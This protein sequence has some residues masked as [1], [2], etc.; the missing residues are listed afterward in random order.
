[1]ILF[2]VWWLLSLRGL[3]KQSLTNKERLPRLRLLAMTIFIFFAAISIFFAYSKGLALYNFSRILV[4]AIFALAT[5]GLI[6]EGIVKIDKILMALAASGI[7]QAIVGFGQFVRQ[8]SLGLWF[9]GEPDLSFTGGG[10]A[11]I[12]V[13]GA[14]IIR[15]YGT[16]PHP[17]ILAAF[18]LLGLFGLYY[19]WLKRSRQYVILSSERRI[20][21]DPSD[22][23]RM[24]T[25]ATSIAIII[26]GLI[27]TFSRAAWLAGATMSILFLGYGLFRRETRVWAAQLFF[28]IALSLT[29]FIYALH[30]Y[31]AARAPILQNEPSVVRRLQYNEM[32]LELIKNKP[33]GVGIGNQVIYSVRTGLYQKFGMDK[34]WMW[35]PIHNLYL[36]IVTELG[37][38]GGIIFSIFLLSLVYRISSLLY[39]R[40]RIEVGDSVILIMF[41]AL[42]FLGLFDHY[43][44]TLQ[45]GRL[46]LWLI[47][48]II[49]G[50]TNCNTIYYN[51]RHE[52][53]N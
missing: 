36:L 49:M 33:L 31:I 19:L 4:L 50:L 10:I 42:L 34:A 37:V 27:L 48:G 47:I 20:S 6:K 51:D 8:G 15:A 30:P 44:W 17:N 43:L 18:L 41:L 12:A 13:E 45:S 22:A 29:A 21:R 7:F 3:A 14:K 38:Q 5:G 35:E 26:L 46:M 28:I 11:K 53:N 40:G 2:I 23:L 25:I 16:L 39:S 1:M 9:L 32:A 52:N 24:T